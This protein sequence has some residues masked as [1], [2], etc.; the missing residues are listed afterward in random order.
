VS[1]GPRHEANDA[2]LNIGIADCRMANNGP[3]SYIIS[4]YLYASGLGYQGF[5]PVQ[6]VSSKTVHAAADSYHKMDVVI[7]QMYLFCLC[8]MLWASLE[9]TRA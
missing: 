1:G 8:S 9:T 2:C 4:E 3:V 5:R 6:M 7:G